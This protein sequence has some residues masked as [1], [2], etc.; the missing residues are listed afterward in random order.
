MSD[1]ITET[2][3]Q[4]PPEM[5]PDKAPENRAQNQVSDASDGIGDI[6][7]NTMETTVT[8]GIWSCAYCIIINRIEGNTNKNTRFPTLNAYEKHV[9]N[10][11]IG[12]TFDHEPQDLN[13]FES[14]FK[15]K[16]KVAD[17]TK[18]NLSGNGI[19]PAGGGGNGSYEL[20]MVV[21]DQDVRK[22]DPAFRLD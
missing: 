8:D 15:V 22:L 14:D 3:K 20:N 6:Y 19:I 13:K 17:M 7:S 11:H 1:G 10:S 12:L 4:M 16:M 2:T 21:I 9:L 18:S 5:P